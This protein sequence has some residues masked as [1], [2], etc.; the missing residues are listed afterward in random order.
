[1]DNFSKIVQIN[2]KNYRFKFWD[3]AGQ[4]KYTNK[5]TSN[6]FH[7]A[8]GFILVFAINSYKSF[9]NIKYWLNAINEYSHNKQLHFLILCNKTDLSEEREVS[10]EDIEEKKLLLGIDIMETSALN[11]VNIEESINIIVQ[12]V[13]KSIYN[14]SGTS[15][16]EDSSNRICIEKKGK[17]KSQSISKC[18]K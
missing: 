11:N 7:L 13:Y 4:E 2:D 6:Y 12:K 14:R 17:S 5:L 15:D 1:M 10:Q 8:H 16:G 9:C 3:T 18:C